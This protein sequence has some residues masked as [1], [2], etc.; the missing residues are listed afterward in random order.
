MSASVSVILF[1][2]NGTKDKGFV[3]DELYGSYDLVCLQEHL[4]T[5]SSLKFCALN[6]ASYCIPE[7]SKGYWWLPFQWT[8]LCL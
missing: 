8:S 3:I 5:A 4:L 6:S 1:N 2:I 7:S